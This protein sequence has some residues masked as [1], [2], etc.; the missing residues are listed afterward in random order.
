VS[1]H[2]GQ[3]NRSAPLQRAQQAA[4]PSTREPCVTP[5]TCQ[6][7]NSVTTAGCYEGLIIKRTVSRVTMHVP[8]P[9]SALALGTCP[10]H[11]PRSR[12]WQTHG[13][14]SIAHSLLCAQA[15]AQDSQKAE[16]QTLRIAAA[17]DGLATMAEASTTL[18]DVRLWGKWSYDDIEASCT[19]QERAQAARL[20]VGCGAER[21]W[22][23][24]AG[25]RHLAG[26]LHRCEAQVCGV[27]AAHGGPVPE[28]ALPQGA[29]PH[30]GEVRRRRATHSTA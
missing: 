5:T 8:I 30:R 3:G 6:S 2:A 14:W 28:E 1:R 7:L 16:S 10:S 21:A 9:D 4:E 12:A 22:R 11:V 26:G 25:E 27:C 24:G 17:W 20:Q 29:V 18:I 19:S 13:G 23:A 15:A